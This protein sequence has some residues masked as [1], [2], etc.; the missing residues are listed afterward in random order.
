MGITSELGSGIALIVL[1]AI[2]IWLRT[3]ICRY[4][5]TWYQKIG[6]EVPGDKYTKQFVF[7]GIIMVVLGFL[8]AS[9][10]S[11]HL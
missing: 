7:I 6:I 8:V 4:L 9:G 10:L 11:R 3:E 5:V 1:G 2:L